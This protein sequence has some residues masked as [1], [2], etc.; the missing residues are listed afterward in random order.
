MFEQLMANPELRCLVPFVK[1]WYGTQSQFKWIDAAGVAHN[2]FQ[3]DG[4]E[5]GDATMPALFCL[6]LHPAMEELRAAIPENATLIAYLDDL[7]IVC[8]HADVVN[9][10]ILA[11][12][13]LHRVCHIDI[14]VGKLAAWSKAASDP[15]AGFVALFGHDA[16]KANKPDLQNGI[17]ILGAPFGTQTYVQQF[18]NRS[19]EAEAQRLNFLPKVPS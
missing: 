9:T 6:A 19:L 8:D 12:D 11:R 7:Y 17:K 2:I 16:W 1:Q 10:I 13:V 14:N 18:F 15:P 5:Q 4:G 3:G